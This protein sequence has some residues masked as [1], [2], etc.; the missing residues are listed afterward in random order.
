M[1]DP[2][3]ALERER[4][5]TRWACRS[6]DWATLWTYYTDP[7]AGAAAVRHELSHHG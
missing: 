6:C 2:H 1:R 5:M 3:T 7:H 4:G